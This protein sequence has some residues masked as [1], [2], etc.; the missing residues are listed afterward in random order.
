MSVLLRLFCLSAVLCGF[1]VSRLA[2]SETGLSDAEKVFVLEYLRDLSPPAAA[3]RAGFPGYMGSRLL[4]RPHVRDAVAGAMAQR[5]VRVGVNADRVLERLG[6]FVFGDI[7]ELYHE[8]GE[9]KQIPEMT[10]AQASLVVGMK[11]KRAMAMQPDGSMAPEIVTEY[12][13]VDRGVMMQMAMRHLGMFKD[14]L[15]INVNH[16]L[17]DKMAKAQARLEGP[18]VDADKVKDIAYE[19]GGV[20]YDE[21][22][23]EIMN[24]EDFI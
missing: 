3:V 21:S 4:R 14:T 1:S 24:A 17:A 23:E 22:G 12:K 11:T 2:K 18:K 20:A 16:S 19:F 10:E 6:N 13:F 5:S 9:F 8:N 7:R 15:E